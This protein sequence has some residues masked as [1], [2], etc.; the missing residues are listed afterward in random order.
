MHSVIARGFENEDW[1]VCGSLLWILNSTLF[2]IILLNSIHQTK[3][4]AWISD[5]CSHCDFIKGEFWIGLSIVVSIVQLV[6]D[7]VAIHI[8]IQ[9]LQIG[10]L[11]WIMFCRALDTCRL[12]KWQIVQ[13]NAFKT[14]RSFKLRTAFG[15]LVS[16]SKVSLQ[17][18]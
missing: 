9:T 1:F 14:L 7:T 11:K 16:S 8:A 4:I 12:K 10:S 3:S 18:V 6:D 2:L 5:C 15:I 13:Y 17:N